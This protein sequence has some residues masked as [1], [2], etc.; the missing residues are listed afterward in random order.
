MRGDDS[1]G[2]PVLACL[3]RAGETPLMLGWAVMYPSESAA[4]EGLSWRRGYT[5][6][7]P[8][9][10]AEGCVS[11]RLSRHRRACRSGVCS[12]GGLL[13]TKMNVQPLSA[14]SG[15][16]LSKV[17]RQPPHAAEYLQSERGKLSGQ[18]LLL[19]SSTNIPSLE[20]PS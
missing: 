12:A 2:Q 17:L 19:R 20:G 15:W 13:P 7:S 10:S 8:W 6:F 11:H 3:L 5:S 1:S 16:P 4:G 9:C 18:D 14:Q